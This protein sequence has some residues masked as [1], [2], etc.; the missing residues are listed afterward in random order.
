MLHKRF[1]IVVLLALASMVLAQERPKISFEQERER[2][3]AN[4]A[5]KA[6]L[7]MRIANLDLMDS[8]LKD[9]IQFLRDV[10]GANIHVNWRALERVGVDQARLNLHMHDI[11]LEKALNLI[12]SD[13]S[14]D[15]HE[16][17]WG[18]DSGV[19]E[20]STADLLRNQTCIRIYDVRDL[21]NPRVQNQEQQLMNIITECISP[22][23]WA[24]NGGKS[25][26]MFHNGELVINTSVE[27]QQA[28][29]NLLEGLREFGK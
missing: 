15:V 9:A 16:L 26:L 25:S 6:A 11:S 22:A 8:S 20:I 23:D 29:E 12:L 3:R 7:Q 28:I 21:L 10:S 1:S 27:N 4:K 18:L 14:T 5:A 17:A 24:Q 13:S 19:I 2:A